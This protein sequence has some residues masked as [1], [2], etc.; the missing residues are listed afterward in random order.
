DR[1]I[2]VPGRMTT[3]KNRIM[4]HNQQMIRLD[5]ETLQQVDSRDEDH[6]LHEIKRAM[7]EATAC[8]ISDYAKGVVTDGVA[9]TAIS[10][11]NQVGIPTVVDSKVRACEKYRGA[12]VMTPNTAELCQMLNRDPIDQDVNICAMAKSLLDLLGLRMV[13]TTRGANGM[14]LL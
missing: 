4:A 1:L 8:I 7:S 9:S 3:V 13:L 12:A 6:L 10:V 2:V 5:R 11:A 14:T